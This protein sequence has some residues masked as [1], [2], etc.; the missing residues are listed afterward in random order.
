MPTSAGCE[1]ARGTVYDFDG[2]KRGPSPFAVLQHTV[3]GAGRLTF[4]RQAHRLKPGQTMLVTI[5]HAH[6]YWLEAG[7]HWHFFWIG[8]TGQE[9]LR[10]LYA[11][12]AAAGPVLQLDR[13]TIDRLAGFCL[14]LAERSKAGPAAGSLSAIAYA[15]LMALFDDVLTQY[16]AIGSEEGKL[17]LARLQRHVRAHLDRPLTVDDLAAVAGLS[18]AHFSRIFAGET[19]LSPAEY[20]NEE[21]MQLAARL[22]ANKA[23][24]VKEVS[25]TCGFSDPNY[26]AKAF[27]RRFHQ[28]PSGYGADQR[29][30]SRMQTSGDD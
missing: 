28:S 22:I 21:R 5:P 12:Q 7:E 4:E 13:M 17:D 20:V 16:P 18:R 19:G 25:S 29:G 6:R 9:A 15:A 1:E 30:A 26:F 10:L 24:T 11:I 23:L 14:D 3:G 8:F 27:R 2:R